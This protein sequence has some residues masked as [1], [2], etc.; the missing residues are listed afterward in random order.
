MERHRCNSNDTPWFRNVM[1][2]AHKVDDEE[3]W[4]SFTTCEEANGA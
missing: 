4:E 2:R 3:E 1:D